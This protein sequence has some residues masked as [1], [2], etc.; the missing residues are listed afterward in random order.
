MQKD[1]DF[2]YGFY[3]FA[4]ALRLVRLSHSA[5]TSKTAA[6]LKGSFERI[7]DAKVKENVAEMIIAMCFKEKKTISTFKTIADVVYKY[8]TDKNLL[9]TK[10]FYDEF[11]INQVIHQKNIN[12]KEITFYR[13]LKSCNWKSAQKLADDDKKT[14]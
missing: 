1:S 7:K 3:S 11:P 6:I 4:A 10:Y 12:I 14:P 8:S 13:A 5:E 9:E 2:L